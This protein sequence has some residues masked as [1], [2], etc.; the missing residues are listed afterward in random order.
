MRH[1]WIIAKC[2]LSLFMR[3][4]WVAL[5]LA[6]ALVLLFPEIRWAVASADRGG[7]AAIVQSEHLWYR[8]IRAQVSLGALAVTS[9]FVC[10]VAAMIAEDR[11]GTRDL[12]LVRPV[13]HRALF[14]G[15]VIGIM[16]LVMLI[17]FG[18]A[19]AGMLMVVTTGVE[20]PRI[21]WLFTPQLV[22]QMC[23][24][25]SLALLV[26]SS[27]SAVV[28]GIVLLA[29]VIPDEVAVAPLG[30]DSGVADWARAVLSLLLPAPNSSGPFLTAL[31]TPI[32]SKY[33][34]HLA[35]FLDSFLYS[36]FFVLLGAELFAR[37]AAR[38]R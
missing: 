33:G 28:A 5:Y 29:L 34:H 1:A 24:V 17:G 7:L 8:L 25:S 11:A 32:A 13:P 38:S 18:T 20:V 2:T 9:A 10:G 36:A 21:Y 16:L 12:F 26:G 6:C 15:K 30:S 4:K 19:A 22:S 3:R 31:E 37:R 35:V 14:L 23:L 27:R